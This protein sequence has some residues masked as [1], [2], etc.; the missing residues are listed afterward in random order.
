MSDLIQA[1]ADG[2]FNVLLVFETFLDILNDIPFL[3]SGF[4]LLELFYAFALLVFLV[5]LFKR[6]VTPEEIPEETK[7][8]DQ[9][10]T[11][12]DLGI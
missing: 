7:I 1:L 9:P 10:D 12:M 3:D 4:T 11:K 5:D 2:L 8:T 6:V